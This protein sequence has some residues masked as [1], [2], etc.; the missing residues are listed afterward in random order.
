VVDR[1]VSDP[2]DL[3]GTKVGKIPVKISY[4]ENG[5]T[6]E[7][8]FEITVAAVVIGTVTG[9]G[10]NIFKLDSYI[11]KPALDALPDIRDNENPYFSI[12]K[13]DITWKYG[14]NN[15]QGANDKFKGNTV[16]RA[17]V[18]ITPKLGYTFSGVN[19]NK[20][21]HKD[22]PGGV[23]NAENSGD[24]TITF[25]AT[26]PAPAELGSL[27]VSVSGGTVLGPAG[28]LAPPFSASVKS[29][30]YTAHSN[31]AL[32]FTINA[33]PRYSANSS[34]VSPKTSGMVP[35]YGSETF[36]IPVTGSIGAPVNYTV[37][38]KTDPIYVVSNFV[39]GTNADGSKGAVTVVTG[40]NADGSIFDGVQFTNST[41]N[42]SFVVP[43]NAKMLLVGGGGGAGGIG[44]NDDG[45]GGGGAGGYLYTEG[46]ALAANTKYNFAAGAGG[47]GGA[48][49]GAGS[50]GGDS[51]IWRDG[52]TRANGVTAGQGAQSP[53][54]GYG[55]P[56][57]Q[58]GGGAGGSG[59]GGGAGG[60][61]SQLPPGAAVGGSIIGFGGAWGNT[62]TTGGGG[63]GAGGAGWN[64][65]GAGGGGG[66]GLVNKIT[67]Q[68]VTYARGGGGASN[69]GTG[70][71][72]GIG[73][74]GHANSGK[75]NTGAVIITWPRN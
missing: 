72:T 20:F 3:T 65:G 53:G 32:K 12:S 74:G 57:Y 4:T 35:V 63:G 68:D 5:V 37:T 45:A 52:G 8:S 31:G 73:G 14:T 48:T 15:G 39:A 16:Y 26:A 28:V 9:G 13:S 67:G 18:T 69:H 11:N 2:A 10:E 75:G 62:G 43:K 47:E 34:F 44:G 49:W 24:V 6:Q 30:T 27:S 66:P 7:A 46:F 17:I 70:T 54:G 60:G 51:Y 36:T 38:V 25:P 55:G 1:F 71:G 59:G 56:G 41:G 58:G 22:A 61:N 21:T 29:Y 42:I 40:T 64:A 23:T 33:E 19:A 50:Q